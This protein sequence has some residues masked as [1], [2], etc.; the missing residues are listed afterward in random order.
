MLPIKKIFENWGLIDEASEY[1]SKW[2]SAGCRK[3]SRQKI[4]FRGNLVK[5]LKKE[6]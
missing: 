4:S 6:R 1:A 5:V 2:G 3:K